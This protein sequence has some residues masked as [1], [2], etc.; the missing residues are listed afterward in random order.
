[1]HKSLFGKVFA[2]SMSRAAVLAIALLSIAT[3]FGE[4]SDCPACKR[5]SSSNS[6]GP[7]WAGLYHLQV[8][9][10]KI[11]GM[12]LVIRTLEICVVRWTAVF[13]G[14]HRKFGQIRLVTL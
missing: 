10:L 4:N 11:L 8:D 6:L 9:C 7:D 13:I 12:K 5:I 3:T 1:M 14:K 2:S